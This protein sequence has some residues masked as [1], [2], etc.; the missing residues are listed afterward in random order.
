MPEIKRPVHV[1]ELRIHRT[2]ESIAERKGGWGLFKFGDPFKVSD[3]GRV[4]DDTLQHIL[5]HLFRE[6][7]TQP[8]YAQYM[9]MLDDIVKLP[10]HESDYVNIEIQRLAEAGKECDVDAFVFRDM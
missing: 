8:R 5:D 4:G 2:A 7:G 1:P 3:I 6:E 10:K 9:F